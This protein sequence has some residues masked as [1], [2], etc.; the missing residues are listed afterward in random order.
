MGQHMY[1]QGLRLTNQLL[2]LT[3]LYR[4]LTSNSDESEV[5]LVQNSN[6]MKE[7]AQFTAP[8]VTVSLGATC[9]I[10]QDLGIAACVGA[11]SAIGPISTFSV[12]R[13]LI[14]T[15]VTVTTFGV[16]P[17][18]TVI[19]IRPTSTT[20]SETIDE[21]PIATETVTIFPSQVNDAGIGLYIKPTLHTA[22]V[23]ITSILACLGG[24]L[25]ITML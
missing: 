5:T 10:V 16:T 24:G 7:S 12:V 1:Y 3:S 22:F 20:P 11:Q 9:S 8:G 18:P 17:T 15:V 23:V 19:T 21:P 2:V 25:F 14:Q 6:E 4:P 13:S